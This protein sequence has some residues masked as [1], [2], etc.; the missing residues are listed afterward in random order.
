MNQQVTFI[1]F[2]ELLFRKAFHS[3]RLFSA[4]LGLVKSFFRRSQVLFFL[5]SFLSTIPYLDVASVKFSG[6]VL[7]TYKTYVER[8]FHV[9]FRPNYKAMAKVLWSYP[10]KKEVFS[11]RSSMSLDNQYDQ[12]ANII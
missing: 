12:A 5:F 2:F 4:N 9:L 11:S 8:V 3:F 1:S 6:N 7:V 10:N